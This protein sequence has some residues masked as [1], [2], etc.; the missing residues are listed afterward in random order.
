MVIGN[1][2]DAV[3][4]GSGIA[5]LA[6]A[7]AA[8]EK[9]LQP[10]LIEKADK[11]GGGTSNSWGLIWVG[12][13]HVARAAGYSDSRAETMSYMT[14]LAGGE[15]F[16][17]NLEA[18]VDASPSVLKFFQDCGI[19]FRL[20]RGV[21]DH[22]YGVAP[23]AKAE[24]R[25]L[26]VELISGFDLGEWRHRV[27]IPAVQPCF[28]TAEE[29]ISWGGMNR[30]SFWDKAL[31]GRRQREDLRGKGVGLVCQF[32]KAILD[33]KIPIVTSEKVQGLT[34]ERGR[35]TG[36]EMARGAVTARK[37]VVLATGGYE[38]SP[39]L[40]RSFE[41]LPGWVSMF[42]AS[43]SGDG[44][45]LGGEVG[46]AIHIIRNNMQLLLGFNVLG[47]ESAAE[48]EFHLASNVELCSPHTVVVNKEGRRFADEAFFQGMVPGLR[49]FE[50]E[51][52][53][54]PNLPCFLIFD[55]QYADAY[56]FGGFPAG[57]EIPGWV[58]RDS[59][60]RGLASELAVDA[61]GLQATIE[62]FNQFARAGRDEDFRR[63]ERAW[64]LADRAEMPPGSNQ[65]LGT[66]EVPPFFGIE[67]HPS[68]VGSAGLLT[69]AH[70]QVLNT[71]RSAI[72]GLYATGNTA[73]RIE[74]GAGYQAGLTLASGMTY[75]Y[76]AVE[77]MSAS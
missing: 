22:Y 24:G 46:A 61:D 8:H 63:G 44:M 14:F 43:V 54:Y 12:N 77:H 30:S 73:A 9:G 6:A 7:L 47:S 49:R 66:I 55:Q 45:I 33:R 71:R 56:S 11:V 16:E 23:G 29:Q 10:L 32:L 4:L 26:E 57:S 75:S 76:L 67:L 40:V 28:I 20:A 36:V 17:A 27:H 15:T 41:G 53:S 18:F 59:T 37:G 51:T 21:K 42:P 2:Y 62:C 3:I 68:A 74:F 38:S 69:N 70:G 58:A 19:P 50:T 64:R 13:N 65:S 48:P 31:V 52:H 25:S 60:I 34:V 5:G 35:V 39:D 1:E 72:P